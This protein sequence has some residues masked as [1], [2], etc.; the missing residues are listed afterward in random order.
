MMELAAIHR[1]TQSLTMM[2]LAA[3][4]GKTQSLTMMELAAIPAAMPPPVHRVA[5]PARV[6]TA[7]PAA[8]PPPVHRAA[9]P[10]AVPPVHRAAIRAAEDRSRPHNT[11][12]PPGRL[13]QCWHRQ[14]QR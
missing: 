9:I 6:L 3:I 8:M 1:E 7:I 12:P 10:A 11:P 2:K 13:M 4:H 14:R 5:I